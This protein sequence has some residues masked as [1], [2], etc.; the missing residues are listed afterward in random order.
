MSGIVEDRVIVITGAGRGI[1]RAYAKAFARHGA[2]V[3]VNDLGGAPDG[4]GSSEAPAAE[5][6][7]EIVSEGGQAAIDTNDVSDFDG[8]RR[9]IEGAVERFGGLDVLINNAGILRDRTIA[10]M[11]IEEWDAVI[12]V[13]LRGTFGPTRWAAAYWKQ[14]AKADGAL[15]ARLISTSSSSGLFA[16]AGQAN[17]A[18]AKAGMAAMTSVASRELERYGVTAN[19]IYPTARSRLTEELL[20]AR[21]RD[22]GGSDGAFD[23]FDPDNFAPV[24]VWLASERSRGIT[25]RLFGLSG[26]RISSAEGWVT[27]PTFEEERRWE[28]DELDAIV[29]ALVAKAAPNANMQGVPEE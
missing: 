21:G 16:N 26:G 3:V 10:N 15:D 22:A 29:P 20:R 24:V 12:R 19:A 28:P 7:E 18:A 23:P 1:G 14:R 27:G 11:S 9:L 2:K 25:G 13:H 5:V 4:S 8:A 17:Y 6:V